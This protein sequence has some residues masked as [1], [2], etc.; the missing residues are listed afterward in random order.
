MNATQLKWAAVA[1]I[2]ALL[3]WVG[4]EAL[5][6]R[7]DD[8]QSARVL[9][10]AAGGI[11]R[12]V[13]VS[14]EDT[15][16]LARSDLAWKV[17]G[18]RVGADQLVSLF[19]ALSD[20]GTSE[21][22][23]TSAAVHERMGVA[24]DARRVTFFRDLD[25]AAVVLFGNRGRDGSSFYARRLDSDVV[26]LYSGPLTNV[27]ENRLDDWRDKVIADVMPDGVAAVVVRGGRVSYTVTRQTDGRWAIGEEL[28]DSAKVEQFL[29]RYRP[30]TATGFASASQLD[31]VDFIP[32]DR[33]LLLLGSTGD[34]LAAVL[35]DSTDTGYWVRQ[36][37]GE[38]IYQLPHQR[39][40][41]LLPHVS[42][43]RPI[44]G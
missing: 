38:T 19:E 6:E 4:S 28:A 18:Y 2:V 37:D 7:P 11:N 25:T 30:L 44:G 24:G 39:V 8:R 15:V 43:F 29:T 12:I 22:A 1:L 9:P 41:Q 14:A 13:I 34:T 31:S 10:D 16:I 36:I 5:T 26:V 23:A 40:D 3:L 21:I 27:L 32:P 42:T 20:S 17:N 33:E 35:F